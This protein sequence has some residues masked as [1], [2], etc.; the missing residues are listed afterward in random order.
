M[1]RD[2]LAEFL[3]TACSDSDLMR[4]VHDQESSEDLVSLGADWGFEFT[5]EEL[6]MLRA[7]EPL[8]DDD[9]ES[10]AGG[11]NVMGLLFQVFKESI[12]QQ[13]Q[14]KAYWLKKLKG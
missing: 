9:L 2:Q 8:S 11:T 14:D 4:E 10:I 1:S 7:D 3:S 5:D 12:N 6:A 13:N